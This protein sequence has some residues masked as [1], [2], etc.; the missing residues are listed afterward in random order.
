MID[1]TFNTD[2]YVLTPGVS[3][4][5]ELGR[6][7]LYESGEIDM[8]EE[9]KSGVDAA[10]LGRHIYGLENGAF[11]S[12]GYLN[13]SGDEWE[14]RYRAG[15]IP[16]EYMI[17]KPEN[18]LAA[19]EMSA[20]GN[21]NMIDGIINNE[22]PPKPSILAQ[23]TPQTGDAPEPESPAAPDKDRRKDDTEL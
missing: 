4:A 5:E 1:Y 3:S 15:E 11:T 17:F 22:P 19:A 23:L 2:Y 16:A 21:Y 8:P 10:A 13:L 20:E 9:W 6:Y 14:V 12:H 18:Y 7:C